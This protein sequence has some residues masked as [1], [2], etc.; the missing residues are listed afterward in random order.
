[1]KNVLHSRL[2]PLALLFAPAFAQDMRGVSWTGDVKTIDL[3]SGVVTTIGASGFNRINSQA[4]ADDG[5]T[6]TISNQIGDGQLIRID[7]VTG[8][9]T[10]VA[11]LGG[12]LDDVRGLAWDQANGR[13]LATARGPAALHAIDPN[14]GVSTLI[15]P[16]ALG[17]FQAAAMS[18]A[19]TLYIWNGFGNTTVGGLYEV[20][21][22]TGGVIQVIGNAAVYNWL[23]FDNNGVLYGGTNI[24][25]DLNVIDPVAGTV[26]PQTPGYQGSDVRGLDFIPMATVGTPFCD[27]NLP[28]STALSTRLSASMDAPMGSGLHLEGSQGPAGEFGYFLTGTGASDPGTML[29]NGMFCLTIGGGNSVGRYNV[30]G[31]QF[32]SLGQFDASGVLQNAVGTSSV[33]SGFDVPSTVPI[34]G[35]PTIMAGATWHYQLWHRDTAAGP[36]A[37]NFSNGLSVTF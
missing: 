8:A 13:L 34:G 36:G 17:S 14:T 10:L 18:P 31:T 2:L 15:G 23:S 11:N 20:D 16:I 32:N 30:T 26:T 24:N 29:S 4:I 35:S 22:L 9:G 33:G 25:G 21:V 6:F 28:N 19:G 27:P 5:R 37:A 3:A 12:D 7:P 1:M